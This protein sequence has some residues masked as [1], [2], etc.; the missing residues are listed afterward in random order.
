MKVLF[1]L[2]LITG[3]CF[4]HDTDAGPAPQRICEPVEL[5]TDDWIIDIT[6]VNDVSMSWDTQLRGCD[7]FEGE[8]FVTDFELDSILCFIP[9]LHIGSALVFCNQAPKSV[10]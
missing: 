6:T 8:L 2:L 5:E 4:A 3:A 9:A 7:F 10:K 1:V